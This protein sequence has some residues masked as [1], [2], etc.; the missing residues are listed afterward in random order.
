MIVRGAGEGVRLD[1]D[2]QAAHQLT[3]WALPNERAD[4]P[5]RYLGVIQLEL[6]LGVTPMVHA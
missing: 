6:A 5:V 2:L 3:A 1:L 4:H